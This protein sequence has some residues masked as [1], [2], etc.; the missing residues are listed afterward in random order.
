MEW[1]AA[2][3][4]TL[5]VELPV[6]FFLLWD[7]DRRRVILCGLLMNLFS[8]PALW[9][10]FPQLLPAEYYLALGELLVLVIEYTSLK[11]FFPKENSSL[12]LLTA[13]AVNALSFLAGV[14]IY[15]L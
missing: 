3:V 6:L 11:I 7:L 4:L 8:H 5:V 1:L 12:L 9:F 15:P 14:L 10:L 2:F 13:F